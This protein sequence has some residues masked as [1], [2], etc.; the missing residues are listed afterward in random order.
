MNN[1]LTAGDETWTLLQYHFHSPSEHTI[2]GRYADMEIH[3]VHQN[4]KTEELAVV[5]VLM[6]VGN[7]AT[8]DNSALAQALSFVPLSPGDV[9]DN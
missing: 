1:T 9:S 8:G 7:N 5:G 6:K 4:M 3:L 2:G